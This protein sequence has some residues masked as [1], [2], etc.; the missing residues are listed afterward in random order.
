MYDPK[1]AMEVG[2]RHLVDLHHQNVS[3]GLEDPDDWQW[4]IM[5]YFWGERH[6]KN[7]MATA[8]KQRVASPA[9]GYW[10]R[11]NDAQLRWREKGF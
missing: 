11:V 1:V 2:F 4:S 10:K 8:S 7:A 6:I 3:E 5:M 9:F